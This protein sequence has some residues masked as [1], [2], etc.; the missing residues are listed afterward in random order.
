MR[1]FAALVFL[2]ILPAAT[3]A[4]FTGRVVKV[5][6]GDTITVL[7]GTRQVKI[8]LNC[9]DAPEN[10][11][12]FG[13]RAKQF[14][15]SL[16][17]GNEVMIQEHGLDKYGRTIGD[18]R[19]S[20]GM[21]VNREIVKAGL[22]WWY[23]RYCPDDQTLRGLEEEAKNDKRGLWRDQTPVPPWSWRKGARQ[24]DVRPLCLPDCPI[25]GNSRS[26][27]YHRPDC[28]GFNDVTEKNKVLFDSPED[29]EVA[30][31]REAKNCP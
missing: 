20:D 7:N 26:R 23:R 13:N 29:A 17:F 21:N 31:Y 15:S 28:P 19:L 4:D 22:A 3:F 27:V 12:S 9:I 18:V 6:D 30:G 14:M 24:P 5:A 16:V 11:Q 2:L 8:R 25:I 10:G 1:L